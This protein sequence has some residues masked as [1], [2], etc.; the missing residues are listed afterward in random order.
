MYPIRMQYLAT[1]ASV[2]SELVSFL[3]PEESANGATT[4]KTVSIRARSRPP[5]QRKVAAKLI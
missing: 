1:L 2:S 4:Q 5:S 3:K